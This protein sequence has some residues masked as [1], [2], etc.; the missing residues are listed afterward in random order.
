LG[1][2]VLSILI[3]PLVIIQLPEDYFV[4]KP[5]PPAQRS[6]LGLC[7]KFLIN[8]LGG[9]FIFAGFVMLFIPGQGILTILFGISLTDFP[10]KRRLQN[11][12]VRVPRVHR[13]LDW[14]R[15]KAKRPAFL[16]P[17]I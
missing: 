10:G 4:K 15:K 14:L 1:A 6:A 3:L 17:E 5:K 16:L 13:S 11:K 9:L 12:I 8:G 7:V 2:F